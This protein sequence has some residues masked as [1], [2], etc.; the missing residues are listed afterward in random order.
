MTK[1]KQENSALPE[2][3]IAELVAIGFARVTD[4][5]CVQNNELVIN[6]TDALDPATGAAIASIERS[7]NGLK[8][9]FYDKLKALELLGKLLGMFDGKGL[10]EEKEQNNLL[11]AMLKA[12][13]EVMDTHDIPE[14]QQTAAFGDDVV[15]PSGSAQV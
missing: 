14:F 7:S 12:T 15:E 11:E 8:V 2:Q 5:L 9:K 10:R 3:V 4:F 1:E 6:A 13:Q